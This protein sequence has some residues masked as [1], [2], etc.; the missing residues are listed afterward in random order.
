MAM[1]V[2]GANGNPRVLD[3]IMRRT[4]LFRRSKWDAVHH[5]NGQT[6]GEYTIAK[7][8][9]SSRW[10]N[11]TNSGQQTDI[12]SIRSMIDAGTWLL[13]GPEA[14]TPETPVSPTVFMMGHFLSTRKKNPVISVVLGFIAGVGEAGPDSPF[15][16]S[17]NWIRVPV[18]D[19]AELLHV[20][21][22]TIGRALEKLDLAGIVERHTL[23]AR[24]NG[25]PRCD[26]LVRL[27]AGMDA[28]PRA[29]RE[30]ACKN[31]GGC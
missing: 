11:R 1:S 18:S 17:E 3:C 6:Y 21:R 27:V 26:S 20:D 13:G 31:G 4:K 12:D 24:V 30:L 7:A 28:M 25:S 19:L 23:V 29:P 5:S 16:R 8:I 10:A 2:F 14:G 15:A 9:A 22:K